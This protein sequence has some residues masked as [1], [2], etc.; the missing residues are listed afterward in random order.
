MGCRALSPGDLP[1]PG[2]EPTSLASS[3]L[4]GRLFTTRA[5]WEAPSLNTVDAKNRDSFPSLARS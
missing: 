5:T 4:A 3:A 2:I 1:S